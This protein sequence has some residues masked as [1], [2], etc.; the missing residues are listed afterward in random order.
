M[1]QFTTRDREIWQEKLRTLA[2]SRSEDTVD[3]DLMYVASA[4]L[5]LIDR[6]ERLEDWRRR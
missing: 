4:L 1:T 6:V 3:D 2:Q 5:D